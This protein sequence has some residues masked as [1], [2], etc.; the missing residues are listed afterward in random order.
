MHTKMAGSCEQKRRRI[1]G[2]ESEK[3]GGWKEKEGRPKRR[4]EDCIR[5]DMEAAGVTEEETLDRA[6]WRRRIRTGDPS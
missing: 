4:L 1:R 5:D 2:K 6:N 3:D